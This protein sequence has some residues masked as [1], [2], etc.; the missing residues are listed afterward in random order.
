[1]KII[2]EYK[3]NEIKELIVNQRKSQK[4]VSQ[5][6]DVSKPTLR[7]IIKENGW[8]SCDVL[9][10][11]KEKQ[12][13]ITMYC[14]NGYTVGVISKKLKIS[15]KQIKEY[16]RSHQLKKKEKTK[17]NNEELELNKLD[18]LER[19]Y[20]ALIERHKDNPY[21]LKLIQESDLE[22][23]MEKAR[24][25]AIENDI[26]LSMS[27]NE[28]QK[29][30]VKEKHNKNSNDVEKISNL[31]DYKE[32]LIY[33]IVCEKIWNAIKDKITDKIIRIPKP[34]FKGIAINCA[35]DNG[36]QQLKWMR[37]YEV[38]LFSEEL[39]QLIE[40]MNQS[41][42][43]GCE[44]SYDLYL[45]NKHPELFNGDLYE[46]GYENIHANLL[47]ATK[48][49]DDLCIVYDFFKDS[50]FINEEI[51][52][53]DDERALFD[54]Y[55]DFETVYIK[56]DGVVKVMKNY[57]KLNI[58]ETIDSYYKPDYMRAVEVTGNAMERTMNEKIK[59]MSSYF[60]RKFA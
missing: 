21:A 8:N 19:I 43:D 41:M 23:L 60:K 3:L 15:E 52:L 34:V 32:Y 49:I 33:N 13:I 5:L 7:K 40:F 59:E 22:M 58:W 39:S 48:D 37:R 46:I 26:E 16:I 31:I 53:N 11:D 20:K 36:M 6:L 2:D 54:V 55:S 27:K 28:N 45:K 25:H 4:E 9:L 56:V 44:W 38:G 47:G 29:I 42:C 14:D 30:E 50:N 10:T 17:I 24:Q 18:A 51:E 57:K 1:M 12:D 35:D